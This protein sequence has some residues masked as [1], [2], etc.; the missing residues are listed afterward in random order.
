MRALEAHEDQ[1]ALSDGEAR[2]VPAIE[3]GWSP[4]QVDRHSASEVLSLIASRG[5]IL[6]GKLQSQRG[7]G[8]LLALALPTP[9]KEQRDELCQG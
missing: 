1:L 2:L 4:N 7:Q 5:V 9:L 6:R 8:R 3:K